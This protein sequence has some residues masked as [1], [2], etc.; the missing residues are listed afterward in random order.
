MYTAYLT[1]IDTVLLYT[2][3]V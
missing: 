1:T 2:G 3:I